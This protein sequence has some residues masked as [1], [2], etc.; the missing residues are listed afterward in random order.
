MKPA[1][2][3][4]IV[5]SLK[6]IDQ[7]IKVETPVGEAWYRYNHDAYGETPSG[8]DYDGRNGVGRLWTLL[9]GERGEY[10]VA[11]GDVF[12]LCSDGLTRPVGDEGITG[13][14]RESK[15]GEDA[16]A[17]L[18]ELAKSNGAPDNVTVVLA[19]C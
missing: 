18:I 3:P 6:L 11:R 15:N 10:D 19:Y 13:I 14:L 12:L 1:S 5:E 7:L 17:R 2:D 4:L 8:G 16:S 9:T